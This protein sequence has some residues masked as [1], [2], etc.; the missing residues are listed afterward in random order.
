MQKASNNE[1]FHACGA[2]VKYKFYTHFIAGFEEH[3]GKGNSPK[4][5]G[6]SLA[7]EEIMILSPEGS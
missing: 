4:S 6:K 2:S 3:K 5:R 7:A 1:W